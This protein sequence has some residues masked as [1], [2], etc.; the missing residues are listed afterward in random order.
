MEVLQV[1]KQNSEEMQD[2]QLVFWEM[3]EKCYKMSDIRSQSWKIISGS[4]Y[5]LGGRR[6]SSVQRHGEM[7][8]FSG[9]LPERGWPDGY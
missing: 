3:C 8:V 6:R 4:G 7:R 1:N 5:W 9:N 2:E